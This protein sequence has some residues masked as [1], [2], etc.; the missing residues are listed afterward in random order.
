MLVERQY[1]DRFFRNLIRFYLPLQSKAVERKNFLCLLLKKTDFIL[2]LVDDSFFF[3]VESVS[4]S[5]FSII[6]CS[7]CSSKQMNKRKLRLSQSSS[8]IGN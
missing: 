3:A 6:V 8:S 1:W 7:D 2:C 5:F 4:R